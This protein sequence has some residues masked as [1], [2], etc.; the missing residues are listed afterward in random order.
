MAT[1]NIIAQFRNVFEARYHEGKEFYNDY[2]EEDH[3]KK[4][5]H[6]KGAFVGFYI[7]RGTKTKFCAKVSFI[8]TSNLI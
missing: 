6:P 4:S 7:R 2:E 1:S 3:V 5:E 8:P